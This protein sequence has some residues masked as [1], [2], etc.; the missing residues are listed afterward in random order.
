[1]DYYPACLDLRGRTC[2]VVGGGEV[3]LR[4]VE[5]LLECGARVLV[6]ARR[7]SDGMASLAQ[8]GKIEAAWRNYQTNDLRGVFLVI[9]A[10]DDE[11]VQQRIGREANERELLVNVVDDPSNCSFIVPAVARRGEL[12]IAVST[13]GRSPALAARIRE[14]LEI[15]FGPEYEE[16]VDLLGDLRAT[17][18]ARFPDSEE[19]KAVWYRIVD[20]NC[21]E[22]IR[23]GERE[24]ARERLAEIL[25]E[26]ALTFPVAAHGRIKAEATAVAVR[27]ERVASSVAP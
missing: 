13:G 23:R 2:L 19:R 21:V 15:M 4:K 18:A 8:E 11:A 5:S 9:A 25:D 10:T 24:K 22:L 20:S 12:A 17:V 26:P 16:W 14:G 27:R 6:V 1:M 3:A 7:P